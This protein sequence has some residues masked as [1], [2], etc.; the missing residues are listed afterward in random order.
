[1]P[2]M[3]RLLPVAFLALAA[4]AALRAEVLVLRADRMIEV[5]SGRLVRAAVLVVEGERIRAAGAAAAV[6]IPPGARVLS[7]GDRTLLPGLIDMHVH[8]ARGGSPRRS[9]IE[10]MLAGPI[11]DAYQAAANA[12]VTLAAGFTTVRS[13]GAND[14]VGVAV[15]K[16]IARGIAAGPRI[17]PAGYQISMNGG[18]GDETGWPGPGS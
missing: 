16:A 11:D 15:D 6:A 12:R 4:P 7:L 14:F 18:P 3:K 1:M 13:A 2:E 17:A 8:L 9:I 5:R 10:R